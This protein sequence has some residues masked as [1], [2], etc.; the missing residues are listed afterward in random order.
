MQEALCTKSIIIV[1]LFNSRMDHN[2]QICSHLF[3]SR[4]DDDSDVALGGV[5]LELFGIPVS[6]AP[7]DNGETL[8]LQTSIA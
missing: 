8:H 2:A 7:C 6:F 5:E 3:D 4:G 1:P